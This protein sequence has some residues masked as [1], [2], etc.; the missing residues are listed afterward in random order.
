VKI[1]LTGANGMLGRDVTAHLAARHQVLPHPR[2]ALE[3]TDPRAVLETVAAVA[4]EAVVHC[5]G[6]TDVDGAEARRDEA[7][8]VNALGARH[9]AVAADAVGA[10]L[11]H[12]STDYV[13]DGAAAEPYT[14][15][16]PPAPLNAYGRSK[17]AG[18]EAVRTHCRRH[19]ILR[20][21]WLYGAHGRNFVG[22][23]LRAAGEKDALDVVDDQVGSPTWTLE[24]ARVIGEVLETG[25][26]GTYHASAEG[27]CSWYAF[28]CAVLKARGIDTPVRPVDTERMPRPARRPPYT[29]LRNLCLG[30]LGV[31]MRPWD[32]ALAEFLAQ[33]PDIGT[34]S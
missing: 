3:V 15:F 18:E 1:L 13:F 17:L 5:A 34:G 20:T 24:V 30:A 23:I 19:F 28:A 25:A 9:V 10:V 31:R 32:E 2:E 27:Q 22:T 33:T 29:V 21:A 4:P 6:F 11:V 26:F 12:V 7:F 16:D 8:R 14:E